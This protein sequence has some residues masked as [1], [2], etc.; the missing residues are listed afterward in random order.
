MIQSR[1]VRR[2]EFRKQAFAE[3]TAKFGAEPRKVRRS[4]AL[5]LSKKW[6]KT[7]CLGVA[8]PG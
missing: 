4:L 5:D 6:Y 7:R 2:L 8:Q 1:A 3:I